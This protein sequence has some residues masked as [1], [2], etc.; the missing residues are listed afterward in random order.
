M[1]NDIMYVTDLIVS[2]KRP[3]VKNIVSVTPGASCYAIKVEE[4]AECCIQIKKRRA[5]SSKNKD[6]V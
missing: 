2:G 1:Q 5:A 6:L 4:P 3:V